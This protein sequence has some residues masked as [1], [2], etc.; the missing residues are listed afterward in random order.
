MS[1][2]PPHRTASKLA[3]LL[4]ETIIH[5]APWTAQVNAQARREAVDGWLEGLEGHLAGFVGPFLQQVLDGTNPPPAVRALLEEAITPTAQFTSSIESIFL[6]G[7]ISSIVGT[8]VSRFCR[9]SRTT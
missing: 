4:G 9:G 2:P 6:W 8:S 3:Q 5:H 7:I 1:T